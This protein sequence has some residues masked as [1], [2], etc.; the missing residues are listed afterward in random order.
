V[1]PLRRMLL[2]SITILS[3]LLFVSLALMW[4]RS[5]W[6]RDG[7]FWGNMG[8]PGRWWSFGIGS[9]WGNLTFTREGGSRSTGFY[10]DCYQPNPSPVKHPNV[11]LGIQVSEPVPRRGW[12]LYRSVVVPIYIP[13]SMAAVAPTIWVLAR[14]RRRRSAAAGDQAAG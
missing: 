3:F 12:E 11:L 2:N 6:V 7:W 10:W 9:N 13:L 14:W 1:R 5:Y 4:V 8:G